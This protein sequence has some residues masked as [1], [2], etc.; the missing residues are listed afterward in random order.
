MSRNVI[1][2]TE[3]LTKKYED[4]VAVNNLNL[5][6]YEGEIFGLLGPNGAGKTTTILMLLGLTEPTLGSATID[7]Y[8]ATKEPI[9]I[10]RIVGYL[11]D[12]VGFYEDMTARENLRFTG[13]LN[14][15]DD[16][17]IESRINSLLERVKLSDVGDRKVGTYSKGMRQRLGIADTLM[18]DPRVMILD[19]P[20]IGLDPAGINEMLEL[21]AE[22]AREDKRTVLISSHQLYQIQRICDRVGI[23]VKGQLLAQGPIHTLGEQV[24]KGK[25]LTLELSVEPMDDKLVSLIKSIREDI[26]VKAVDNEQLTVESIEDIRKPLIRLLSDNDYKILFL[27]QTGRDLDDIYSRYFAREEGPNEQ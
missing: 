24:F 1:I 3:N 5:E 10:K 4:V 21:I 18:K 16:K 8:N 17:E 14:N 22:L 20:T 25:P 9:H 23:F 26:K 15:L 6:I 11:P 27:K 2:K 19:E 12:N 13:R 7:G